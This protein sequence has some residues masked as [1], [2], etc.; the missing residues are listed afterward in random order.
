M[1]FIMGIC[2]IEQSDY[3]LAVVINAEGIADFSNSLFGLWIP[4]RTN[5][6]VFYS[7]KENLQRARMDPM[8]FERLSQDI[9]VL[10]YIRGFYCVQE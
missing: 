8:L 1:I 4:E 7:F 2:E 5:V 9:L 3:V 6:H 10:F